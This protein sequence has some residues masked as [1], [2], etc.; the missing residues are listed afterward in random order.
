MQLF[1]CLLLLCVCANSAEAPKFIFKKGGDFAA[2]DL[3]QG[4][5]YFHKDS[6]NLRMIVN[7]KNIRMAYK[8]EDTEKMPFPKNFRIMTFQEKAEVVKSYRDFFRSEFALMLQAFIYTTP[9][10][11][12]WD[13]E[14]FKAMQ[15]SFLISEKELGEIFSR[16]VPPKLYTVLK[17][18][19]KTGENVVFESDA[20]GNFFMEVE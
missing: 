14:K 1:I 2:F 16:G 17:F 7:G 13:I 20:S 15:N 5:L 19:C 9:E 6:D 3:Q 18:K 12:D 4:N 8:S 10:L 11:F